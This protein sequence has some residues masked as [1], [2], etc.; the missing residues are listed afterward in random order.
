MGLR[1]GWEEHSVEVLPALHRR[2]LQERRAPA[3]QTESYWFEL[4]FLFVRLLNK[5]I[6][7]YIYT[8]KC[9]KPEDGSR[10]TDI[11]TRF[12]FRTCWSNEGFDE[13][14]DNFKNEI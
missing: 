5:Y 10:H 6:Y 1:H 13:C 9:S 7:I 14:R 11:W 2:E 3:K 4:Q 8:Y 12:L